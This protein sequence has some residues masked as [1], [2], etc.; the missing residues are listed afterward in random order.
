MDAIEILGPQTHYYSRPN[1]VLLVPY[2][3]LFFILNKIRILWK[4]VIMLMIT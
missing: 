4:V 2:V 1:T 3:F